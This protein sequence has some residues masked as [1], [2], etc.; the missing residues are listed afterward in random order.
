MSI[1]C[2]WQ[3]TLVVVW[4]FFFFFG[5]TVFVRYGDVFR[6]GVSTGENRAKIRRSNFSSC[7]YGNDIDDGNDDDNHELL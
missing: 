6:E 2:V 5:C 4:C 7:G 3:A 1:F